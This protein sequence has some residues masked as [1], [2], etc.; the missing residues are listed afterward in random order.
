M[1]VINLSKLYEK[2]IKL[3]KKILKCCKILITYNQLFDRRRVICCFRFMAKVP[4]TSY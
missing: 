3:L 1:I 4:F 2:T